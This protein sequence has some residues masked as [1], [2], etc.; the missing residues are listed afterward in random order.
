[1]IIGIDELSHISTDV[2]AL[3][4]SSVA[5]IAG[6]FGDKLGLGNN[7]DTI[8]HVSVQVVLSAHTLEQGLVGVIDAQAHLLASG[9]DLRRHIVRG[10]ILPDAV[11]H[12]DSKNDQ[13]KHEQQQSQSS[14]RKV[15]LKRNRFVS[16]QLPAAQDTRGVFFKQEAAVI[17]PET[18]H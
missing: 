5:D 9:S 15:L 3:V 17:R 4:E 8:R 1:M 7:H 6:G 16:Q 10:D 14:H 13:E 2:V 18:F 12:E 11:E